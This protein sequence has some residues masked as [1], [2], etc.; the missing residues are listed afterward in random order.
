MQFIDLSGATRFGQEDDT[1]RHGFRENFGAEAAEGDAAC[2]DGRDPGLG[3]FTL[4][5]GGAFRTLTRIFRTSLADP[6]DGS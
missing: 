6:V 2:G 3:I 4:M 5:R 1:A